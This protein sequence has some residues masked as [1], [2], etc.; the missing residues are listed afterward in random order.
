VLSKIPEARPL[1]LMCDILISCSP[2]CL[3]L[4]PL[5][6]RDDKTLLE[7]MRS[8]LQIQ[9]HHT[10]ELAE[11]GDTSRNNRLESKQAKVLLDVGVLLHV[12]SGTAD[13]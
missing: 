4:L 8:L 13:L 6:E 5:V 7:A 12:T 10:F 11:E 2:C 9:T 1:L 3:T